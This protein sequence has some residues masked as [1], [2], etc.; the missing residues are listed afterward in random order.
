MTQILPPG[1]TAWEAGELLYSFSQ[2][3]LLTSNRVGSG[4]SAY[5][6]VA[7]Y[8]YDDADRLTSLRYVTGNDDLLAEYLYELDGVG[9]RIVVTE[10]QQMPGTSERLISFGDGYEQ[11]PATA[12]SVQDDAYLVVWSVK[13]EIYGRR[14]A[15]DGVAIGEPFA[16]GEG[17]EPSVAYSSAE[18]AYLV[19][20]QDGANIWGQFVPVIPDIQTS[21]PFIVYASSTHEPV[22]QP[23]VAYSEAANI[24]LVSWRAASMLDHPRIQARIVALGGE[25]GP[26]STLASSFNGVSDPAVAAAHDGSF[27]VVWRDGKNN[28]GIYG[29]IF[30][31]KSKPFVFAIA[32]SQ[33]NETV[34][35]VAWNE[36]GGMYLVTWQIKRDL[37]S[38]ASD[39]QGHRVSASGKLLGSL[40]TLDTHSD[41]AN[42]SLTVVPDK[43]LVTW[44]QGSSSEDLYGR[45]MY[46]DGT[47]GVE[48]VPL[49]T[50]DAAQT[51]PAVIG[52]NP[53][54]DY[55]LAWLDDRAG[56]AAVYSRLFSEHSEQT[57]TTIAYEYDPLYRLTGAV[58]SGDI[59]ASYEYAYDAVGNME[60]YTETLTTDS[61][62]ETSVVNRAFNDANQL[63]A[64]TNTVLGTTSYYYD[65][66]GNMTQILPPG[67]TAGEVGELLY[68]FSQRNLLTSNRVGMGGGVYNIVANYGY[69]GGGNRIQQVDHSDNTPI[70]TTYTNDIMGLTQVLVA[71]DG[72]SEVYNLFGLDLISQDDG[73]G[74]RTLLVDGLGSVRQEMAAGEVETTSTYNPYGTILAQTGTSGTVYGYT[75]EQEDSATGLV[76]LRARYYN[77]A[78]QV[79]MG[80]DPWRGDRMRPITQHGY[81]YGYNSPPNF[82]DPSGHDPAWCAESYGS[83]R[84]CNLYPRDLIEFG[85]VAGENWTAPEKVEVNKAAVKIAYRLAETY[86]EY[87]FGIRSEMSKHFSGN[88]YLMSLFNCGAEDHP[89]RP[90]EAFLA[91]YG[92]P[93]LFYKTGDLKTYYGE[94]IGLNA[95]N[96]PTPRINVYKYNLDGTVGYYFDRPNFGYRWAT[97]ELGHYFE[98]RINGILGT[99]YVRDDVLGKDTT[100]TRRGLDNDTR[101]YGFAYFRYGWQQSPQSTTGEEFAD[102]FLGWNYNQWAPSTDRDYLVGQ[103]R[104]NFMD[105]HMAPWI[106]LVINRGRQNT[107]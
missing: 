72:S 71:N 33:A 17:L 9:N 49:V 97:H 26:V 35:D 1:V 74:M 42:P 99:N 15:G 78:L 14:I 73:T 8:G 21:T 2:R 19:V 58:Y 102:M 86:N 46:P 70:T 43:W 38:N 6:I 83:S 25:L 7:T 66:N 64:A 107:Q 32:Q 29:Y 4:G 65:N 5:N 48:T 30:N 51:A 45:F 60:A 24:F 10:T 89:L 47:V 36:T 28:N 13:D 31:G 59:S 105:R 69:D 75:G 39:I 103:A 16:I 61:G 68:S 63:I 85:G 37:L 67:V 20:W 27:L 94:Y 44:Q 55:L 77:P 11:A 82:N 106:A 23:D 91:Y 87:M 93:A 88:D 54:G 40:T 12:Y 84:E 52:G 101:S 92:K 3:N 50:S 79:F 34:P 62:T 98:A 96:L 95:D 18:N 53:N 80:K 90:S 22:S 104:S 81:A 41:V 57:T 76:Y 56:K 100:I